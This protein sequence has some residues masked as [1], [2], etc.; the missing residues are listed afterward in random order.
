M[1]FSCSNCKNKNLNIEDYKKYNFKTKEK[2]EIHRKNN[3]RCP[4]KRVTSCN[5]GTTS[6]KKPP[7]SVCGSLSNKKIESINVDN[8]LKDLDKDKEKIQF[9]I[10]SQSSN[11]KKLYDYQKKFCN[12][13]MWYNEQ[14]ECVWKLIEIIFTKSKIYYSIVGPPGVGKT[15]F[16]KCLIAVGR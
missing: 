11:N 12:N 14:E 6:D 3:K 10:D 8:I 1:K 7:G 16:M 5:Q 9:K 4:C 2:F 15:N 13:E